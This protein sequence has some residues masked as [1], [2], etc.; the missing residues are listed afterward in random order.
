MVSEQK[1]P[2]NLLSVAVTLFFW[3]IKVSNLF[4]YSLR[5]TEASSE[6]LRNSFK[7]FRT[8]LLSSSKPSDVLTLLEEFC[9]TDVSI[10]TKI[11][12][13]WWVLRKT[14]SFSK[15]GLYFHFLL[16]YDLSFRKDA[17]QS[18]EHL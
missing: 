12:W 6:V 8:S 4:L 17:F 11:R 3:C 7:I 18:F 16:P 15:P 9:T 1:Y 14:T 2:D 5:L 13:G 10:S